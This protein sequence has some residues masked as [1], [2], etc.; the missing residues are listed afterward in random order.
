MEAVYI[1][2]SANKRSCARQLCVRLKN[3]IFAS[4][5]APLRRPFQLH[6]IPDLLISGASNSRPA[7]SK[8][9]TL[10]L[11]TADEWLSEPCSRLLMVERAT[12]ALLASPPASSR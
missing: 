4:P 6:A 9:I 5:L 11:G 10:A 1:L 2:N 7:R 8:A 3:L 12:P